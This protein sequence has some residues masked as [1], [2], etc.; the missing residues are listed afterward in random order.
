MRIIIEL[1]PSETKPV[2]TT[3][4]PTDVS[5]SQPVIDGGTPPTY[6]VEALSPDLSKP[7]QP[8][9]SEVVQN[10]GS[11]PDWLVEAIG[12]IVDKNGKTG[13]GSG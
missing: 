6:L 7:E 9:P 11:A 13:V 10:A 4:V 5:A 1:E 12:N 3:E 2:V 8:I